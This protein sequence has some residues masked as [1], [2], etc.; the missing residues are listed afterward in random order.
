MPGSCR[1]WPSYF[2][3]LRTSIC[4]MGPA[5]WRE[6]S[7]VDAGPKPGRGQVFHA[8]SLPPGPPGLQ[9]RD[10]AGAEGEPHSC[11]VGPR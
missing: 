5:A 11:P 9:G 7:Q 1:V 6:D 4:L 3:G 2:L 10:E 8:P